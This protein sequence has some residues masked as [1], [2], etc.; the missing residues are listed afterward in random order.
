LTA[1][2]IVKRIERITAFFFMIAS[3]IWSPNY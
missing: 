1:K 2:S 3:I